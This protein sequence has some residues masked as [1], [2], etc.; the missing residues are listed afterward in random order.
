M[1]TR[2]QF[3]KLRNALLAKRQQI[4]AD[5]VSEQA[6]YAR[7]K[8]SA[9]RDPLLCGEHAQLETLRRIHALTETL[10]QHDKRAAA[11]LDTRSSQVNA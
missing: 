10:E 8:K 5:I 4:A 11:K 2:A 3:D 6:K 9:G 1:S 7:Q